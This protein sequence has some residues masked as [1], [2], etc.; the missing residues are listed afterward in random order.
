MN[1]TIS[2]L[3]E[4]LRNYLPD[5]R[6]FVDY[7]PD[8]VTKTNFDVSIRSVHSKI[9]WYIKIANVDWSSGNIVVTFAPGISDWSIN[10][11]TGAIDSFNLSN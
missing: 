1:K 6:L 4:Y 11:L 3:V 9:E 8:T 5:S 7:D 10:M 2:K